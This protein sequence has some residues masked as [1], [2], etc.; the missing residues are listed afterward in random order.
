MKKILITLVLSIVCFTLQAQYVNIVVSKKA[1][2]RE[3]Y[4]A[5]YLQKKLSA[6]GYTVVKK[7]G[8]CQIALSCKHR[9]KAEGY[10]I[11]RSR[12]GN[13]V[14]DNDASGVI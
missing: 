2:N 6:M 11:F 1:T 8:D 10:Q 5:E 3:Q 4:A 12:Q 13:S 9:G 14:S 7:K